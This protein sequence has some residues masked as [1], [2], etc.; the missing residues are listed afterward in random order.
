MQL[1]IQKE[2]P[3]LAW[4]RPSSIHSMRSICFAM[5]EIYWILVARA[6][7]SAFLKLVRCRVPS[8][9][10]ELLISSDSHVGSSGSQTLGLD[11]SMRSSQGLDQEGE[12]KF[13][14]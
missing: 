1:P 6:A 2:I 7:A 11:P 8:T 3:I 4:P 10:K 5:T 13:V 14:V 9:Y 12:V